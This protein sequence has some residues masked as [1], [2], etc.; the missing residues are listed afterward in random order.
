MTIPS[1]VLV[2]GFASTMLRWEVV[3]V[4]SGGG[5]VSVSLS[6]LLFRKT[7]RL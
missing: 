7:K 3:K 1:K 6:E 4:V 2:V 5:W